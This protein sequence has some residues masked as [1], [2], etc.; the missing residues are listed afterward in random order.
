ML[1]PFFLA[2]GAKKDAPAGIGAA[3]WTRFYPKNDMP[4][5]QF[6]RSTPQYKFDSQR[7]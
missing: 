1:A 3:K 6:Q 2:D 5:V 7:N 4:K